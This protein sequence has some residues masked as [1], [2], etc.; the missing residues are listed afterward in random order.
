[1][2]ENTLRALEQIVDAMKEHDSPEQ[3]VDS[4]SDSERVAFQ[5]LVYQIQDIAELTDKSEIGLEDK[6]WA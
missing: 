2:C 4:L 3:F 1:M 6:C 5:R